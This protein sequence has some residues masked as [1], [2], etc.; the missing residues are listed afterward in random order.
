M[1]FGLV[2]E[3]LGCE[4]QRDPAFFIGHQMPGINFNSLSRIIDRVQHREVARLNRRAIPA[5]LLERIDEHLQYDALGAP[6]ESTASD[7]AAEL[8]ALLG[9]S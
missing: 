4:Y 1:S 7:L 3:V 9:K 6:S 5:G 8:R 2:S